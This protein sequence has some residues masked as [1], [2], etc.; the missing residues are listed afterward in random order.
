MREVNQRRIGEV[1]SEE[2]DKN[3]RISGEDDGGEELRRERKRERATS[4]MERAGF[5]FSIN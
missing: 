2:G 4:D 1:R 3:R 5:K